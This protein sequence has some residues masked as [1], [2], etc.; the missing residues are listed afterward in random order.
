MILWATQGYLVGL[1]GHSIVEVGVRSF[2]ADQNA[3]VPMM[4]SGMGLLV[5]IGLAIA[6]MGPLQASGIALANSLSYS[7]QALIL[8]LA[9]NKKLP[10]RLQLGSSFLRGALGAAVGGGI[11]LLVTRLLPS[12]I[13]ALLLSVGGM[14]FGAVAAALPIW[15]EIKTLAHL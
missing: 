13:P 1:L 15:R 10:M 9:L 14:A 7:L 5:Y 2:Y 4:T 6:L 11:T 8:I 12:S 3:K